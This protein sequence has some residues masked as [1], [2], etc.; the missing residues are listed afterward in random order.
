VA[1]LEPLTERTGDSDLVSDVV[2]DGRGE[3][4]DQEEPPQAPVVLP[5]KAVRRV[6]LAFDPRNSRIPIRDD[7]RSAALEW[8][9]KSMQPDDLVGVVVLRPW[10]EWATTFTSN[11]E[12][13]L[14]GLRTMELFYNIP[15]RDRRGEMN[16][17][18]NEMESLCVDHSEGRDAGT[19]S[20]RATE[21][22]TQTTACAYDLSRP[23]VWDWT[24]QSEE[25]FEG[26]RSLCGELAAIPGQKAV[27]LFS[28]GM[29]EDPATV[30]AYTMASILGRQPVDVFSMTSRLQGTETAHKLT[31]LYHRA[32]ASDVAFFTLDTRHPSQSVNFDIEHNA[33]VTNPADGIDP[34]RE[35]YDSSRAPLSNL[36]HATGGRPFYGPHDLSW[37]IETAADAFFGIYAL[38]YYRSEGT[39]RGAKLKIK[40]S[41][42]KVNLSYEKRPP[43]G[44]HAPRAAGLDMAIGQPTPSGEG[45]SQTLPI[46]LIVPLD[47]LP[48]R[49][50]G[51]G[52]GCEMGVFVQ[53]LRPDGSVA[54]EY[55]DTT[56]VVVDKEKRR[57]A[58]GRNFRYVLEMNLPPGPMRLHARLSDDRQDVLGERSLDLTLGQGTVR[59]GLVTSD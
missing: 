11:R 51:G 16:S 53:A 10:P 54:G 58:K 4:V 27:I 6:V 57:T 37:K 44:R 36:A 25:S 5:P 20:T 40:V 31:A 14:H 45:S 9:E 7:W 12:K 49:K 48:L 18:I 23:R 55:F 33:R 1:Y 3:Q 8:A 42:N 50:G 56:G 39:P 22:S 59:A 24:Q 52:F 35:M 2:Y 46:A 41:R 21:L 17:F 34:F 13:V 15:N 19:A 28:E 32:A 47:T 26:L 43:R 30:A 29:I 38:G